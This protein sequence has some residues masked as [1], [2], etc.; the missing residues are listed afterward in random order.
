[1][2]PPIKN[3]IAV[4]GMGAIIHQKG[5]H[6]RVWAPHAKKV[7][8]SGDFNDWSGTRSKMHHEGNGYWAVN[9]ARAKKCQQYKYILE[10][11]NGKFY[12][13][14]PYA[15]EV[16]NSAGNSIITDPGFAWEDE[17]F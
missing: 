7:S 4:K 17:N 9:I 8:V 15:R 16:T 1:M 3:K 5:V 12:K 14:D 11:E 2:I 10:T 13:N 6:F